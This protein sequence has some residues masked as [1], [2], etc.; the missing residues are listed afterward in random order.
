MAKK[1]QTPYPVRMPDDVKSWLRKQAKENNRS[2]HG[3]LI[4]VLQNAKKQNA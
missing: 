4:T 3:E 1:Q 2:M